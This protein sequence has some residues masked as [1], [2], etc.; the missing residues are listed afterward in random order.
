MKNT[1]TVLT[2]RL[3]E[4]L[5]PSLVTGIIIALKG[6]ICGTGMFQVDDYLFY[7]DSL[8]PTVNTLKIPSQLSSTNNSTIF[9]VKEPKFVLFLSGLNVDGVFRY[10]S[11]LKGILLS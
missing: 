8:K 2:Y 3:I 11:G 9:G 10:S 1:N 5:V 6:K 7:G 4:D